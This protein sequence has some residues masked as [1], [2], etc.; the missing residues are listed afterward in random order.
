ML[1][2]KACPSSITN[3]IDI[4]IDFVTAIEINFEK[5]IAFSNLNVS[6]NSR[7]ENTLAA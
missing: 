4:N 3:F 7:K 2:Q 1:A 6:D 5:W